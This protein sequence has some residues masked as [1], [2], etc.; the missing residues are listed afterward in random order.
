MKREQ[1]IEII[2]SWMPK[3]NSEEQRVK[4]RIVAY[5][6]ANEILSLT[7]QDE[8]SQT[9]RGKPGSYNFTMRILRD[10]VNY[11]AE[12][13][14]EIIPT[15]AL[16]NYIEFRS[17]SKPKPQLSAEEYADSK[18]RR[19]CSYWQGLYEGYLDAQQN[20]PPKT[21]K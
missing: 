7:Q 21:E 13:Y 18:D 5:E 19:G 12:E 2:L 14:G 9:G 6:R 15:H 10:F 1:I 4:Q 17:F 20:N 16:R 11:C 8:H 3:P